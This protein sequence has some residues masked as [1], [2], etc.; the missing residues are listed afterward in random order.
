MADL[1]GTANLSAANVYWTPTSSAP[2]EF[3]VG[4][5][6]TLGSVK[7]AEQWRR[8]TDTAPIPTDSVIGGTTNPDVDPLTAARAYG[9][10][11]WR[12]RLGTNRTSLDCLTGTVAVL[13]SAIAYKE[14]G[15]VA[16]AD[17]GDR[18]RYTVLAAA[19]PRFASVAPQAT[20]KAF[21]CI[22]GLGRYV[23][24]EVNAYDIA[25]KAPATGTYT[26]GTPYTLSGV[27][28][29]VTL[30]SV[31][32]KGLY[33]NLV[34]YEVLPEDGHVD[35]PL[36]IWVQLKGANTAEG[37]QTVLVEGRWQAD[38]HDPD[39]IPATGDETYPDVNLKYTLPDSTWTPT[40]G[41][42]IAFSVAEPGT[43][44]EL[45]AGR[46]RPQRRRGRG[47]PDEPVRQR[48]RARRDGSLRREHR[49][50]GGHRRLRRHGDRVLEPRA[51]E[52]DGPHLHAGPGRPAAGDHDGP[53]RL[54]GPLLDQARR[55]G[56]VRGRPGGRG[57]SG[58]PGRD[59]RA[60][61]RPLRPRPPS[62][63]PSWRSSRARSRCR[64]AARARPRRAPARSRSSRARRSRSARRARS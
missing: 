10:V 1:T 31:M 38:F 16:V 14:A 11:Y 54:A 42:P 64:S 53:G 8:A 63:P 12:L 43:L 20:A 28:F 15:N 17:G 3:S 26:A 4:A 59:A 33:G 40:G 48:L 44:P 2:V 37:S 51:P 58:A 13:D 50:P 60:R 6:G 7:V 21:S 5:V 24:R 45:H 32:L 19:A 27:E 57:R 47:L 35:Q 41:G 25:L 56:A 22:D 34:D 18:G 62:A 55:G 46:L 49:L 36:R 61:L 52:P 9:N 30:P 23:G 39:G 29:S